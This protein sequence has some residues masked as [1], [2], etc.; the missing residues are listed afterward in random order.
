M[1]TATRNGIVSIFTRENARLEAFGVTLSLRGEQDDLYSFVLDLSAD[2]NG[3]AELAMNAV[4]N[5]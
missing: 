1:K 3:A 2:A 4:T 5:A